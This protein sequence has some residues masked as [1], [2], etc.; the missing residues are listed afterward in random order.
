MGS[1]DVICV[2]YYSEDHVRELFRSLREQHSTVWR[3]IV[4]DNGSDED[5]KVGLAELADDPRTTVLSVPGNLGYY[6]GAH[7]AM[8]V[9][10][11]P[12]ATLAEWTVVC[13]PDIRF[14]HPGFLSRLAARP[15]G[16]PEVLAPAVHVLDGS[17][18]NPFIATFPSRRRLVLWYLIVLSRWTALVASLLASLRR[19]RLPASPPQV[20]AEP[21]EAAIFAGHGSLVCFSRGFFEAGLDLR[22]R[23][24]LY[25]EELSVGLRCHEHG[26]PVRYVPG[27]AVTHLTGATTGGH[28]RSAQIVRWQRQAAL[29]SLREAGRVRRLPVPPTELD[30]FGRTLKGR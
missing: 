23:N 21:R 26:I 11:S 5:G 4:V 30:R 15:G 10:R 12:A 9:G 27:L 8:T 17:D 6:G 16:A 13:N 25:G 7:F 14:D 28:L 3:L 20:G 29:T 24:F 2:N 22:H 18:Q 19:R 1:V